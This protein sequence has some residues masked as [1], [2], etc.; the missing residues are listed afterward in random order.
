MPRTLIGIV[1]GHLQNT[2]GDAMNLAEH[3]GMEIAARGMGVICGGENGIGEAACRGC[4]RA[5]GVTIGVLKGNALVGD[6]PHL[7]Y[8]I[9][10]SMDVASNNIL[11][12][13]SAGILALDGRYGTLNELALALDFGKP[14]ISLGRQSYLNVSNVDAE[15]FAHYE[16]YDLSR[17]P[18]ILDRLACMMR[19]GRK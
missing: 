1:G 12:W 3:L 18:E 19:S 5:G 2:N 16:G 11:V 6:H 13:S 10:T 17:I 4:R 9:L 8:A 7:D 14:M 15:S